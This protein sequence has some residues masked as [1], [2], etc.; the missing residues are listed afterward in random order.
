MTLRKDAFAPLIFR[1]R[2]SASLAN[3]NH[4]R[5]NH[6]AAGTRL[7]A[8]AGCEPVAMIIF[9]QNSTSQISA[10]QG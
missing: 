2:F 6:N 1:T 5:A 8:P 10:L 7:V 9:P 3:G 4:P